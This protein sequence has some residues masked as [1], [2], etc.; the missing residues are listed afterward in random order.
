ML[1]PHLMNNVESRSLIACVFVRSVSSFVLRNLRNTPL[2][3]LKWKSH[4]ICVQKS[5]MLIESS[6]KCLYH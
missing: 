5:L 3:R 6:N 1:E 4:I 2:H